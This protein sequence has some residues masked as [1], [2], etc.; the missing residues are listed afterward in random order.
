MAF[1]LLFAL[2]GLC[3]ATVK[4]TSP[5][6]GD[7]WDSDHHHTIAWTFNATDIAKYSLDGLYI[8]VGQSANTFIWNSVSAFGSNDEVP[9]GGQNL[10]LES[11]SISLNLSA[12]MFAVGSLLPGGAFIGMYLG[13]EPGDTFLQSENFTLYSTLHGNFTPS[14]T[15]HA[16]SISTSYLNSI[17]TVTHLDYAKLV[18]SIILPTTILLLVWVLASHGFKRHTYPQVTEDLPKSRLAK[19]SAT[20]TLSIGFVMAVA[21]SSL[22]PLALGVL[23]IVLL[24]KYQITP[25]KDVL[26]PFNQNQSDPNTYYVNFDGT[27]YTT[28]ASWASSIASLL[29]GFIMSLYWFPLSRQLESREDLQALPTPQ[30]LSLLIALKSGTLG[31][32]WPALKYSCSR[33]RE[34][35]SRALAKATTLV[36]V[37]TLLG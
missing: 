10:P 2:F 16:N 34:R 15:G 14:L 27:R 8:V 36:L 31:S 4:F 37:T 23:L 12:G 21:M 30:Q 9:I 18:L 17:P 24:F 19:D 11:G 28:V 29:P 7:R 3:T 26:F 32:L 22:V 33:L 5:A 20:A 13:G 6:A 25:P 1:F 35:Q